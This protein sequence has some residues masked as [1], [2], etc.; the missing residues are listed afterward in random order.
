MYSVIALKSELLTEMHKKLVKNFLGELILMELSKCPMSGYD[1][2][3][4]IHRKFHILISSGTVY[5]YLY[6]LERKGLVEGRFTSRK[7][8]YRLTKRGKEV[9]EAIPNLK[10]KILVLMV[11]LF[12]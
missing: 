5:S 10:D 8:R 9:A 11:N 4:F 3:V 1:I 12:S 7:R 6:L 2:V